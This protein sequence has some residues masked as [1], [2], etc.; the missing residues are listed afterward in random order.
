VLTTKQ[1]ILRLHLKVLLI[2]SI[3]LQTVVASANT[4]LVDKIWGGRLANAG[5]KLTYSV[6]VAGVRA[7]VQVISIGQVT[8]WNGQPVYSITSTETT[9]GLFDRF[10]HFQAN[11]QTYLSVT[12]LN[13][14]FHRRLLEDRKYRATVEVIYD[15]S[16]QTAT[17][18]KNKQVR[19]IQIV[20]GCQ[21]ELSLIYFFR[22]YQL[23]IGETYTFP[24]LTQD[25]IRNI[26]CQISR[27]TIKSKLLGKVDA[28]V[29]TSD[30]YKIWLTNDERRIPIRI[31]AKVKVG[32]FVGSLI[33]IE[34]LSPTPYQ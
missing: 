29:I 6:R 28:L 13:P 4:A 32:K 16:N 23:T 34:S 22:H 1:L 17:Y 21:D 12:E 33:R 15:H 20:E 31:E 26:A 18:N 11:R 8:S 2:V 19:K 3:S 27:G 5:D 10:Y 30:R 25:K 9:T 14:L 24:F 7:G